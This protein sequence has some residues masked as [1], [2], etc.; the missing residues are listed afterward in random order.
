MKNLPILNYDDNKN[1]VINPFK[2]KKFSFPDK[3]LFAFTMTEK[4]N[5]FIADNQAKI[6]GEYKRSLN[7]FY[8]YQITVNG[9]KIGVCQ[10]PM[11]AP[12]ATQFIEFLI[13]NGSKEILAVGSCGALKTI[14]ENRFIIPVKALR[15]EGTSYHYLPAERSID[16]DTAFV[17][18]LINAL[19]KNDIE[20]QKV[21]TWTTDAFFRETE[22]LVKE[23]TDEGYD[24]VEMECA[25]LTACAKFR[26]VS[27]AQILFTADTLADSNNWDPRDY[28]LSSHIKVLQVG[29]RALADM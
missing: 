4:F 27:F 24:V 21:N 11:G 7:H 23:Y 15:D 8:V 16:L 2:K 19:Q 14:P 20:I 13:A 22:K 9:E 3:L 5:K 1:A 6:I 10:G 26:G 28:G 17:N 29:S 25:A 18:K 12:A